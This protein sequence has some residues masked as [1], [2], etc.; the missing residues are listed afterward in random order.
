MKPLHL[1]QGALAF[2]LLFALGAAGAG[3]DKQPYETV[4]TIERLDAAFDKLVP[5]D[6]KLE[7]LAE[8]FKWTEGPCYVPAGKYVLFSDIPNN[9]VNKWEAGKGV[10]PFLKPSGYTGKKPRPGTNPGDEPGSNGLM[11]D[12]QGRLCLCE[13]GD[14]RVTRIEK[15][16]KKTTLADKFEGKRFNSPNDLVFDK[17]GNL[18]FTDPPYGLEKN[19]DDP[20]RELDFCGVYFLSK[21]GKLKLLTKEMSRPNGITLSP[22]GKTL[23]V[24]NS[25]PKIAIWKAFDVKAPGEITTP[26]RIFFDATK[27]S[28]KQGKAGLPDGMK[29]DV[30][31]NVWA[32][33]PGGVLV[34]SPE[35]KH[36]G[37]INTGVPTANCAFGDDGSTLYVAANHWLTRIRTT[38]KGKGF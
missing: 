36:L 31:G 8:G 32:T 25:D 33:G 2:W 4:G 10:T 11:L 38:T 19:W 26:G 9:V 14:R 13:H 30:H 27:W 12:P 23:Y 20:A 18:Y 21:D 7:K 5:K 15:D 34:F 24:A 29:V 35:G 6:A 17:D 16:G 1:L 28:G 22:D 37:T 3:Q